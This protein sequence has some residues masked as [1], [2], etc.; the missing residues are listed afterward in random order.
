MSEEDDDRHSTAVCNGRKGYL[1]KL[2]GGKPSGKVS[3]R[4]FVLGGFMLSYG[5]TKDGKHDEVI[6]ITTIKDMH[7]GES[8][9]AKS[10]FYFHISTNKRSYIFAATTADER[11]LW[12]ASLKCNMAQNS[13]NQT[14]V[15]VEPK[16][17]AD[18]SLELN[19]YS[20]IPP[21]TFVPTAV[22]QATRETRAK[23]GRSRTLV[24]QTTSSFLTSPSNPAPHAGYLFKGQGKD[25]KKVHGWQKKWFSLKD[26]LLS[27]GTTKE[28]VRRVIS[29]ETIQEIT[30]IYL[31]VTRGKYVFV[32]NTTLRPFILASAHISERTKWI[33]TIRD[34]IV[35][36]SLPAI[37]MPI[38]EESLS[39]NNNNAEVPKEK[40]PA[41]SEAALPQPATSPPSTSMMQ[42]GMQSA[43]ANRIV[44]T[45]NMTTSMPS[46]PPLHFPGHQSVPAH[47][48]PV[49]LP[50]NQNPIS[51]RGTSPMGSPRKKDVLMDGYLYKGSGKDRKK[52]GGWQ[53]RHFSLKESALTYGVNKNSVKGTVPLESIREVQ[54][55]PSKQKNKYIFMLVTTERIFFLYSSKEEDREAWIKAIKGALGKQTVVPSSQELEDATHKG[56]PADPADDKFLSP[57]PYNKGDGFLLVPEHEFIGSGDFPLSVMNVFKL[58]YSDESLPFCQAFHEKRGDLEMK[59]ENWS[60]HPTYGNY[61]EVVYRAPVKAAL[62]PKSTIAVEC[63]RYNMTREFLVYEQHLSLRDVPYGDT[64]RVESRWEYKA[65][66]DNT[67]KY[68]HYVG[69]HWLKNPFV[70]KIII[71]QTMKECKEA[72][73]YYLKLVR[74]EIKSKPHLLAPQPSS[75]RPQ[76]GADTTVTEIATT[77]QPV[78][79][80]T[81]AANNSFFMR[82]AE[83]IIFGLISIVV[84]LLAALLY[85][86]MKHLLD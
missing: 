20:P 30:E 43:P 33:E 26:G 53:K 67:C 21:P 34:K 74:E 15:S 42:L 24:G 27:Y 2:A 41:K 6:D 46:I 37:L 51:P 58:F 77:E 54:L 64:F 49:T 79:Q 76:G 83:R 60:I 8:D 70:K 28:E 75:N 12:M 72:Y 71:S 86:S 11:G 19:D 68:S 57:I 73:E 31:P 1:Y 4:W 84:V 61:R 81:D 45:T 44:I 13:T 16:P 50:E 40:E 52:P 48:A 38:D 69:L 32:L 36:S 35:L 82:H 7:E 78:A 59:V 39:S 47:L 85:Q 3:K 5:K 25:I 17:D 63:Q 14:N 29:V 62:G 66:G 55:G 10:R 18:K 22:P 80:R 9:G 56:P 23:I 65:T